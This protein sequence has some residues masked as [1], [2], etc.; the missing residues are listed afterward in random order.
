MNSPRLLDAA[1]REGAL[2]FFADEAGMRSDYHA[3][4]SWSPVGETPIVEATG[5]RFSLNMLI[6]RSMLKVGFVS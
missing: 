6:E 5:A 2:I 4:T 3:G 1:L